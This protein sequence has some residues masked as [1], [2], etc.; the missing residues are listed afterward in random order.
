MGYKVEL[1]NLCL[2]HSR[3][4]IRMNCRI[5]NLYWANLLCFS[6]ILLTKNLAVIISCSSGR[7]IGSKVREKASK[8]IGALVYSSVVRPREEV[9]RAF[10]QFKAAIQGSC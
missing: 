5:A 10:Q 2:G 3:D 6:N 4:T 7:P 8:Q 1:S 9:L